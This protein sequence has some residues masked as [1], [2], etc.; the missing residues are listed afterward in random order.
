MVSETSLTQVE[1]QYPDG[2][3]S[4]QLLGVFEDWGIQLSEASLRKYVQLGLLPR[5]V[6]VGTKGKH[7]GS[8]GIYPVSVLRQILRVKEMMAANY[9]IEQIQRDFFFVRSELS[10]LEQTLATV[11]V[12]LKD[13]IRDRRHE[14]YAQD[15]ARDLEGARGISR[16]LLGRLLA[17]ESR[18]TTRAK[19][20][21]LTA[22]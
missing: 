8:R 4:A 3:T 10:Q 14:S 22:S 1:K 13:V 16:E 5:S 9:T 2:L 21:R 18:L 20:R 7:S 15:V 19:L 6:R 11:F 12:I 17:I